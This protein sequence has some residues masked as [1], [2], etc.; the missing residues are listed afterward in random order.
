MLRAV[1][2]SLLFGCIKPTQ[3]ACGT[4]IT[5]ISET[6]P[7]CTPIGKIVFVCQKKFACNLRTGSSV[8]HQD[9]A[10]FLVKA[11]AVRSAIDSS[12][13]TLSAVEP[14][15]PQPL[16]IVTSA[17]GPTMQYVPEACSFAMPPV[18]TKT[19]LT[20]AEAQQDLAWQSTLTDQV[21]LNTLQVH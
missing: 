16:S 3:R 15:Q 2:M 5:C 8:Q 18:Q 9:F 4:A 19:V 12:L 20:Q 10:T 7:L 13:S 1:Y 11:Q 17:E 6:W 14:Q 21:C